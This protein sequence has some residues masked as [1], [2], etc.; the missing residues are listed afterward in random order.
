MKFNTRTVVQF[1]SAMS[2]VF[3]APT[4]FAQEGENLVP[5]GSFESIGKKPKRLG[6]IESATGWVSPTGV[7]ADLF[8]ETKI[9]EIGVPDNAY[10]QED[11]QEG[12]NYIGVTGFSY[13]N[14][15][16]RSYVMT[17]LEAPMKKGMKY[18]V[19]MYVSLAEASKYA[20]N[21][22]GVMFSKKQFG[23]ESKVSIIE[24]ASIV[25]LNNDYETI[26]ARYD[27]TEI[28]GT[29]TAKG[30]EKYITLGNFASNDETRFERMKKDAKTKDI[31]VKQVISA[32]YYIDDVSVRLLD[33]EK[34]QKCDC[35]QEDAGD[36]YSTLIY[37]KSFIVT[38]EMT[39]KE[40]VDD[41]EVYF[42]FGKSK[43]S[44][45]GKSSLD[46]IA[47][48]LEENPNK[49]LQILGHNNAAEDEVGAEKSVYAD[50]DN[51]RIGVVMKYLMEKGISESRMV[52][53]RKGSKETQEHGEMDDDETKQAKNRRVTFVLL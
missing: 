1:I 28:C 18:C 19:K 43:L 40:K 2:F 46:F 53:T 12:D 24:D 36:A 7:R 3:L 31:R 47:K 8:V 6:K 26:S 23:T 17:K 39:A 5:N 32:Y 49:K 4:S 42:A 22:M 52:P 10:G 35:L 48:M 27:W 41:R 21:N 38:E 45:E 44:A 50:M 13:G 51:N 11:P 20:S 14:K 9:P 34:G 25:H 33:Q 30:G 37:Q 29:Y 15:V 16:P